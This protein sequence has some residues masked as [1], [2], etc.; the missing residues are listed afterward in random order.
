MR[1]Y[2]VYV[3]LGRARGTTAQLLWIPLP[4][5]GT[6]GV[7]EKP[8]QRFALV[9]VRAAALAMRDRCLRPC[10]VIASCSVQTRP[11]LIAAAPQHAANAP[12][13][14]PSLRR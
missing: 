12:K 13:I 11:K 10:A 7:V 5:P 9:S 2:S 14:V 6:D 8:P 4:R 3:T 1:G